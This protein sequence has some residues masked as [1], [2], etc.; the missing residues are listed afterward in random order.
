MAPPLD[1]VRVPGYRLQGLASIQ[2]RPVQMRDPQ[3]L[4]AIAQAMLAL[5]QHHP[6]P[7]NRIRRTWTLRSLRVTVFERHITPS[8]QVFAKRALEGLQACVTLRC[9]PNSLAHQMMQDLTQILVEDNNEIP[10]VVAHLRTTSHRC[11]P[12]PV[13]N[14]RPRSSEP[15]LG[16]GSEHHRRHLTHLLLHGPRMPLQL[17]LSR[18][19]LHLA[20]YL[21]ASRAGAKRALI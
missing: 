11:I 16:I 6:P 18:V 12:T 5:Q 4:E 1:G 9:I 8:L 2:E 14:L 19:L 20:M 21:T 15:A 7:P 3:S 17:H 10:M 13:M